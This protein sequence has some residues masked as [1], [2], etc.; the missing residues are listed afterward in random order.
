MNRNTQSGNVALIVLG[1]ILLLGGVAAF[2]M[3][4]AGAVNSAEEGT[5]NTIGGIAGAIG[6]LTL[7]AGIMMRKNKS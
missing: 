5:A 6:A 3:V 4:G 7:G 1:T 2:A